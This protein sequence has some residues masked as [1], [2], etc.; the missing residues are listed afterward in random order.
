[1]MF[2]S[3]ELLK[4]KTSMFESKNFVFHSDLTILGRDLPKLKDKIISTL[5][6]ELNSKILAIPTFNLNTDEKKLIDMSV[7]DFSA[8]SCSKE[9]IKYCK[10]LCG[11]RLPNPIHSYTFFPKNDT[12]LSIDNNKSFGERSIFDYFFKN[13]FVWI[14]FGAK[15]ND[16]FTILHNIEFLT[17][18]PYRKKI[19]FERSMKLD[20]GIVTNKYEYF[21]RKK[22]NLKQDFNFAIESLI[23]EK[24]LLYTE[25][26]GKP[27]YV[28]KVQEMTKYLISKL[29]IDPY[30]LTQNRKIN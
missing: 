30:F 3:I 25:F 20:N 2:E 21:A 4:K 8:G 5:I 6:T 17:K 11:Y 19:V 7:I 9:A 29:K 28:G 10:L 27:I 14:S 15:P 16:S 13:D 26:T 1:M 12:I 18:V 23:E 22:E 24:L